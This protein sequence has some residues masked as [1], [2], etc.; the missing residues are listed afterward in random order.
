MVNALKGSITAGW[1]L[2][3]TATALTTYTCIVWLMQAA[4][5]RIPTVQSYEA[6]TDRCTEPNTPN[7]Y[8]SS[9]DTVVSHLLWELSMAFSGHIDEARGT[10]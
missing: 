6:T 5:I 9:W 4:A 10:V 8:Y 1:A 2:L 7:C 3:C